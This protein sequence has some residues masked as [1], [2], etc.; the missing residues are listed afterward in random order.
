MYNAVRTSATIL[1]SC[2]YKLQRLIIRIGVDYIHF[3]IRVLHKTNSI[4]LLYFY[5]IY[6][7]NQVIPKT[8]VAL[9]SMECVRMPGAEIDA[10]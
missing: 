4:Y 3:I 10:I 5:F 2:N 8:E 9:A 6:Y 7:Y 1:C